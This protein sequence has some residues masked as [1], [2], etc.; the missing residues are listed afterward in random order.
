MSVCVRLLQNQALVVVE[1]HFVEPVLTA[2]DA[3]GAEDHRVLKRKLNDK[4][5]G[6][7]AAPDS[8]RASGR[9]SGSAPAR[10][11]APAKDQ[12]DLL[13]STVAGAGA[14]PSDA[15]PSDAQ[16]TLVRPIAKVAPFNLVP[17]P[18]PP[19][20]A[21]GTPPRAK[22]KRDAADAGAPPPSKVAA[23]AAAA[24]PGAAGAAAEERRPTRATAGGSAP[25]P[26]PQPSAKALPAALKGKVAKPRAATKQRPPSD[27]QPVPLPAL[28]RRGAQRLPAAHGGDARGR[29]RGGAGGA[30]GGKASRSNS[31]SR[32]PAPA[33]AAAA[34]A[35][36]P[37]GEPDAVPLQAPVVP[38]KQRSPRRSRHADTPAAPPL[39]APPLLALP[40]AAPPAAVRPRAA[41]PRAVPPAPAPLDAAPPAPAPPPAAPP[42]AALPAPGRSRAV[43]P[44][45]AQPP[46]PPAPE[47]PAPAPLAAAPPPEPSAAL[48]LFAPTAAA[49]HAA[50]SSAPLAFVMPASSQPA[51]V[52]VSPKQLAVPSQ[53]TAAP[54]ANLQAEPPRNL[55]LSGRRTM[56][57]QY[58]GV[59]TVQQHIP[60]ISP[61]PET[62]A[63]PAADAPRPEAGQRRGGAANK[64]APLLAA[65]QQ[66]AGAAAAPLSAGAA[67]V[68]TGAGGVGALGSAAGAASGL[69]AGS[70]R[71]SGSGATG[72][73][74]H[75]A[76]A[77]AL[78]EKGGSASL[79]EI[80]P[81]F[82]ELAGSKYGELSG[83]QVVDRLFGIGRE[84]A[85]I[86]RL[87]KFNRA[88]ASCALTSHGETHAKGILAGDP[89]AL[90]TLRPSAGAKR[91]SAVGMELA[92]K[93]LRP[94]A[95]KTAAPVPEPGRGVATSLLLGA[96][97]GA[98]AE[99]AANAK[100]YS[101]PLSLGAG[102]AA[103]HQ[104]GMLTLTSGRSCCF[105]SPGS[106]ACG[107]AYCEE[108]LD[109]CYPSL[110]LEAL[111]RKCPKC[112]DT[113][114]CKV[115]LRCR[116]VCS[117]S[118]TDADTP[119]DRCAATTSAGSS[120]LPCPRRIQLRPRSMRATCCAWSR[121]RC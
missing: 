93:R 36:E 43:R 53:F 89:A 82:R 37:A 48:Q 54:G 47:P 67:P 34:A 81:R 63:P 5:R 59:A 79:A 114:I 20:P 102:V 10:Q 15:A 110:T 21:A 35:A 92:V 23:V 103:C 64:A 109:T 84:V 4:Q 87:F 120:L 18:P 55:A 75:N 90:R 29:G 41:A 9:S 62:T 116:G 78:Y 25:E 71:S 19:H 30:P 88:T 108:C 113:C 17:L 50:A 99:A 16:P 39:P 86:A 73:S 46:A 68:A 97:E 22:R 38:R 33:Q 65:A 1:N 28:P 14:V 95:A 44:R 27:G 31:R 42:A 72:H 70:G 107:A 115:R 101:R 83:Q 94:L 121:A 111:A 69:A 112:S 26:Q 119:S 98:R 45:A 2:E 40:A 91:S 77:V 80:L 51:A 105:A 12:L 76:L 58:A 56:S 13:A 3:D 85:D 104:C 11:P 7:V 66:P 57:S 117:P 74:R 8:R 32:L 96:M 60:G 24:A 61:G 118:V 52:A 100:Q 6:P 49:H 106:P